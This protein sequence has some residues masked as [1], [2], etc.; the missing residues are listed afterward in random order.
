MSNGGKLPPRKSLGSSTT[1][2]G[3]SG[4]A[5]SRGHSESAKGVFTF[6]QID[7]F[8]LKR[9]LLVILRVNCGILHIFTKQTVQLYFFFFLRYVY[10]E[11]TYNYLVC[12]STKNIRIFLFLTVSKKGK[13]KTKNKMNTPHPHTHTPTHPHT[14]GIIVSNVCQNFCHN[15]VK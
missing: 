2:R 12:K 14:H 7:I 13:E 8:C 11:Y 4:G 15:I 6:A 10:W 1:S 9:P 3:H 5:G